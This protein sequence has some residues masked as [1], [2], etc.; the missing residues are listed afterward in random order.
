[1]RINKLDLMKYGH[2][3]D[4]II[5]FD[6]DK[7]FNL[8]YGANE[9][10]KTTILNALSCLFYG[11]P[12]NTVYDYK[13]GSPVIGAELEY[14]DGQVISYQRKKGARTISLYEGE[15]DKDKKIAEKADGIKNEMQ[16][17]T[18][19]NMFA[20]DHRILREGGRALL[21]VGGQLGESL[22]IASSGINNLQAVQKQMQ[23][24]LDLIYKPAARKTSEIN[25]LLIRFKAQEKLKKDKSLRI[26]EFKQSEQEYE[27]SRISLEES[28]AELKE[29]QALENKLIRKSILLQPANQYREALIRRTELGE[30]E[31]L[32]ENTAPVRE[33]IQKDLDAARSRRMVLQQEIKELGDSIARINIPVKFIM[34]QEEIKEMKE[35]L[36]RYREALKKAPE[37]KRD[38]QNYAEQALSCL[39]QL[40]PGLDSLSEAE[41]MRLSLQEIETIK[42]LAQQWLELQNEQKYLDQEIFKNKLDISL[43]EQKMINFPDIKDVGP[44]KNLLDEIRSQGDIE[45]ILYEHKMEL[46]KKEA[47]FAAAYQVFPLWR[48]EAADLLS[49]RAPLEDTMRKYEGLFKGID[50]KL[51]ALDVFWKNA[52]NDLKRYQVQLEELQEKGHI[53]EE[54]ILIAAR[55]QRQ[56]GWSIIKKNLVGEP[57]HGAELAYT[58][59]LRL[60]I[61]Y[62]GDVE[63]AD[64]IADQMRK[65]ADLT[66]QRNR[67]LASIQ[68]TEAR[69]EENLAEQ[70]SAREEKVRLERLWQA[71]W[72]DMP[73][74][75]ILSPMEMRSWISVFLDLSKQ[76]LEIMQLI[77]KQGG[78]RESCEKAKS[79]LGGM[80]GM[81]SEASPKSLR[82]LINTCQNTINQHEQ[83]NLDHKALTQQ[84]QRDREQAE[85]LAQDSK[86]L[87][88]R[89]DSWQS[90]W[91]EL[92]DRAGLDRNISPGAALSY[93]GALRQMF[94]LIDKRNSSERECQSS[95]SFIEGFETRAKNLAQE[96]EMDYLFT[97]PERLVVLMDEGRERAEQDQVLLEEK[98]QNLLKKE[99][100]LQDT[101]YKLQGYEE[102]LKRLLAQVK[103]A[104]LEQ[105][106]EMEERS[107]RGRELDHRIETA[108]D[109]LVAHLPDTSISVEEL[110]KE[111]EN[112][113]A[114]QL[115]AEIS[116]LSETINLQEKRKETASSRFLQAD[117]KYSEL[118]RNVSEEAALA[119]QQA[120][121]SAARI[122]NLAE[123]YVRLKVARKILAQSIISYSRRN[124]NYIIERAGEF[125]AR[126]TLNSFSGLKVGQN[127]A[128]RE[129]LLG[130]RASGD[131]LGIE[132][133]SEGTQDQLYLAIRLANIEQF[134]ANNRPIPL[135]MDDLLINFDD[136]RARAALG[137]LGELASK[138]QIIYFTHHTHI[139]EMAEKQIS[140]ELIKIQQLCL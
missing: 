81:G 83:I 6:R 34:H 28:R 77:R 9:S 42:D 45:H 40:R 107:Q 39:N 99:S 118:T 121:E 38:A 86:R 98:K 53:P 123:E 20:L 67:L 100:E 125:F 140:P 11:I 129:V 7:P 16:E 48:G 60:E 4:Y 15:K 56:L 88:N 14:T 43:N 46:E 110:L 58:A 135:I 35:E 105:M 119:A 70:E 120:Q 63:Q 18:F 106:Q 97:P 134:T 124:Q 116:T 50:D 13:H 127:E 136:E 31:Y 84:I 73:I 117:Y 130:T 112:V 62:E 69:L 131:E 92:M 64:A 27:E 41:K 114:D 96:T 37:Q 29:L 109:Q 47:N 10:G 75:R 57:D 71:E 21:E 122:R 12:K 33:K 103:C 90:T 3:T 52:Q 115:K 26:D 111:L 54:S 1:M 8:I 132:E 22:F 24:S 44:L 126:L 93:T 17:E 138:L 5:E 113:D 74:D 108:R 72:P 36:G 19:R 139:K 82:S 65:E 78:L 49:N 59:G 101:S 32:P 91:V 51:Q 95:W 25:Q 2:F 66:A 30:F 133:M 94:E 79:M 23:D 137:I 87:M 128:Y 85:R 80:L 61:V 76:Y 102:E 55:E 104:D 89:T 68:D